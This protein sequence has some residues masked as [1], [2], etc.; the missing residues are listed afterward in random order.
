VKT[1]KSYISEKL[2]KNSTAG[3]YVDDFKKSD[4]P[5]FKGKS[6]KKKQKM[7]I[8]AYLDAKGK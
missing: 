2:G 4:A 7:A 6:D 5:Q 1:F 8:A 3:D